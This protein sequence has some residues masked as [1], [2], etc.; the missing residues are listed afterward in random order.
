MASSSVVNGAPNANFKLG[1][2]NP[3]FMPRLFVLLSSLVILQACGNRVNEPAETNNENPEIF[4]ST[5]PDGADLLRILQARWQ[6]RPDS[7]LVL[8]VLDT[9]I[10]WLH[11]KTL[12]SESKI[13]I[14]G[15][16][17][18]VNCASAESLPKEGWCFSEVSQEGIK[19]YL[20]SHCTLDSLSISPLEKADQELV[21]EKL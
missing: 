16:C 18:S 21:F 1:I 14:D 10:R 9:K 2:I 11:N 15:S 3:E 7:T 19:C 8:E 6:N 4:Q 5:G 20:V 17:E 12:V 13:E